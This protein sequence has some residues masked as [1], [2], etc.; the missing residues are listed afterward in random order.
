MSV[1]RCA[2]S[3]AKSFAIEAALAKG[4][5]LV[6]E[7]RRLEDEK[8]RR[9]EID[10]AVGDHPLDALEVGDRPARTAGAP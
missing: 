8:A 4:S 10:L 7:M 5:P 3:E 6:L 1:A 9:F 2:A